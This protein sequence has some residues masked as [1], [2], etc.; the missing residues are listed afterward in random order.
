[1]KLEMSTDI[2]IRLYSDFMDMRLT[3]GEWLDEELRRLRITQ[4]RFA[5]ILDVS[6]SAV[7]GWINGVSRPTRRN[8]RA[9][10]AALSLPASDVLSRAG[11]IE[12]P[13]MP[14]LQDTLGSGD[15]DLSRIDPRLRVYMLGFP[16]LQPE[17]QRAVLRQL[18]VLYQT[19]E[20]LRRQ[21]EI[22]E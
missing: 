15:V 12:A 16:D 17:M 18:E 1:M 21:E 20:E 11:W 6:Q 19:A 8:C 13:A 2:D 9:I 5:E 3:F 10:A 4:E 22:D 7:S 14:N